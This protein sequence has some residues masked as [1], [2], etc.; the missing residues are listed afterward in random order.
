MMAA[1]GNAPKYRPSKRIRSIG[2]HKKELARVEE[3]AR[4]ADSGKGADAILEWAFLSCINVIHHNLQIGIATSS[5]TREC[6]HR[7]DQRHPAC[8]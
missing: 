3:P 4:R 5:L 6:Q 1:T 8:R 2:V 7:F